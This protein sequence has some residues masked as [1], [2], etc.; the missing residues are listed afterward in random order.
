MNCYRCG[1]DT[2]QDEY[3]PVCGTDMRVF[4]RVIRISNSYYNDGLAKANVR[5]L[6]GAI[7]SLK[8]SLKCNKYNIEARN[9]LGL[10]YYEMG[11]IV[12]AL[13]EWVISK[14][15]Q[16]DDNKAGAY[17]DS[18]QHN[19]NQLNATNQTVRKFNQALVYCKQD[20][21]DLAIIQLKKVLTLNPKM[22]R[23]HQLLALLYLQE[24]RLELAKKTLR[25]AGKI[26]TDNTTTL[27]YLKEVNLRMKEKGGY[28]K[29]KSDDLISY[30]SG[31]ETIIMPKR[32]R[33]SSVGGT[34]LLV[35]VGLIVGIAVTCFLFF[36]SVK[37]NA[38]E[39]AREKIIEADET[40]VT[41]DQ[42]I[43]KLESQIADLETQLQNSEANTALIE[44]RIA[45]YDALLAA[46]IATDKGEILS[47]GNSLMTVDPN[48]LSDASKS[49]YYDLVNRIGEQYFSKLYDDAYSKYSAGNYEEAI[50]GLNVVIAHDMNYKDGAAVYYLAQAYRKNGDNA[51][52]RTY[53]QYVIDN[54]PNTERART[55]ENYINEQ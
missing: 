10:I 26:D 1:T 40:L 34:I 39:E 31:N 43:S 28:K 36:P 9:L 42:Q 15:Y 30:Q 46:A 17:L 5:N 37:R 12:A 27:R 38:Q 33:E 16:P 20:S 35:L 11:E 13:S 22:V 54:F 29:P 49:I 19:K 44:T 4:L 6:S 52:A 55:A 7:V 47:A 51:N 41:S 14:S 25:N 53:Y 23:A 8:T 50:K 45:N 48:Y 3:C 2:A 24:D 18:I 21:R 32:F